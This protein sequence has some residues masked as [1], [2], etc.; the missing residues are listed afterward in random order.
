M[1]RNSTNINTRDVVEARKSI[2]VLRVTF[3]ILSILSVIAGVVC[4]FVIKDGETILNI[5]LISFGVALFIGVCLFKSLVVY[6]SKKIFREI[7]YNYEFD[8]DEMRIESTIDSIK[9]NTTF[10]YSGILKVVNVKKYYIIYVSIGQ[11]FVSKDGFES[12]E[13][14][15]KVVDLLY[16]K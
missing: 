6:L 14:E 3:L 4:Q 16:K 13:D 11:Y 9:T 12:L 10:K 8:E 15:N 2:V 1:V 7:S 5:F